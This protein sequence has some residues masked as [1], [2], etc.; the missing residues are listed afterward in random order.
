MLL[1]TMRT[2]NVGARCCRRCFLMRY[3][4]GMAEGTSL[5]VT[6]VLL[7]AAHIPSV[8]LMDGYGTDIPP[9]GCR[10][11]TMRNPRIADPS[12][13]LVIVD[14]MEDGR[15]A[16]NPRRFPAIDTMAPWLWIAKISG[17]NEREHPDI[18]SKIKADRHS[19]S[20]IHHSDA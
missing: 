14:F 11:I 19:A 3:L 7:I 15:A 12:I 13:L 5:H 18:Q 8:H 17:C 10:D 9:G 4:A 16:V 6:P 1:R 2:L 20:V